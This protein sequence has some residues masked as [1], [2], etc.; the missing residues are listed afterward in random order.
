MQQGI[1]ASDR[2]IDLSVAAQRLSVS[3]QT[4]R[5]MVKCGRIK[6]VNCGIR[7]YRIFSS[8]IDRILSN[9]CDDA[10]DS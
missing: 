10:E 1:T 5:R 8:E 9:P 2:L 4:V 6:Q 3:V 7:S